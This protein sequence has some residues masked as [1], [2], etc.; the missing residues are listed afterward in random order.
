MYILKMSIDVRIHIHV[1][2][3]KGGTKQAAEMI[4]GLEASDSLTYCCSLA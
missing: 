1:D 3:T 4:Q 2:S